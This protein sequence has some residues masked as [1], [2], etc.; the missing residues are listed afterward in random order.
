MAA[1][2]LSPLRSLGTAPSR[3]AQP[4]AQGHCHRTLPCLPG[5]L[6]LPLNSG[7]PCCIEILL[8]LTFHLILGGSLIKTQGHL[9]M[10]FEAITRL[11]LTVSKRSCLFCLQTSTFP[12][13]SAGCCH[14]PAREQSPR[15]CL[16]ESWAGS[17]T[18]RARCICWGCILQ[19]WCSCS[20]LCWLHPDTF[21]GHTEILAR[22]RSKPCELLQ[23]CPC[24]S[25]PWS[26]VPALLMG[27]RPLMP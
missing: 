1:S 5:L 23:L 18:P 16:Q 9:S 3:A 12:W 11:H 20:C 22:T 25:F 4:W 10:A 8:H 24:Q 21:R 15:S 14:F 6:L 7:L 27:Q 19:A 17:A 13:L 26:L 2:G